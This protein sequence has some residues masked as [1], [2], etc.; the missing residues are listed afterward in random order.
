MKEIRQIIQAIEKVGNTEKAVLATVVHIE[1]S[2]Y[3]A[4]GARMLIL[5][6]GAI[7]GAVSGGCLEGD[8]LRKAL[9]VMAE[10][11]PHLVTYDTSEETGTA[12]I[13][14]SLGC[15]GITRI[16]LEPMQAHTHHTA[17]YFL[18][19]VNTLREPVVLATF[20]T[21]N[22]KK[23]TAQGT[24]LL[25]FQNNTHETNGALPI[26]YER[27]QADIQHVFALQTSSFVQFNECTVFLEY[28]KPNP[29]LLIAGAGND[30]L[31]LVALADVLGWDTTLLD[32]RSS[33]ANETRFPSCQIA[34]G[35]PET[36][37]KERQVDE[38]TAVIIMSHNY[39][40]DKAV[41]KIALN[42]KAKYIGILGPQQKQKRLMDEL[43]AE[44][45]Q[46][47]EQQNR[48]Y[49][50]IGLNIG[51]ETPEEIALSIIS[52]VKAVFANKPGTSLRIEQKKHIHKRIKHLATPL[53]QYAVLVLAA[54]QS[55]RLG[56][57]KQA[58]MYKGDTLLRNTIKTAQQLGTSTIGVVV[59]KEVETTR[60]QLADLPVTIIENP[61]FEEGMGSSIRHG[62]AALQAI[63]PQLAFILILVCDQ[64]YLD[65]FHLRQLMHEQQARNVP[66]AASTYEGRN[67]VPALFRA[68]MFPA[69]LTLQGDTGAKH[70]I[71]HTENIAT[72]DFPGGAF[73]IDDQASLDAI[74]HNALLTR[75]E[76]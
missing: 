45:M 71:A 62:V 28:I 24:H 34:V 68:D 48:V 64:P 31:P 33:Y 19:K 5:P 74:T 9:L 43:T 23:S 73:D 66:I 42:S 1:G 75:S 55:K 47:Q 20:F 22:D 35:D 12:G 59:G 69:L 56:S 25:A 11:K 51:A 36:L 2:A 14:I 18:Q 7:V 38:E 46:I 37:M 26:A 10:Q 58:L 27:L 44:G 65:S 67:G 57:P 41:L 30:V 4:P 70:V 16:L 29:A 17:F 54:G 8:V 52:E 76:A 6:N 3:R 40:Y 15:S 13:A 53:E 63:H 39:A 49:G 21:P 32:G 60:T 61:Q 72:V 50:P